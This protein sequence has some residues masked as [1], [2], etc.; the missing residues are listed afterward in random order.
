MEGF[1]VGSHILETQVEGFNSTNLN[2]I[3]EQISEEF[4][5]NS[6]QIKSL[7]EEVARR[8]CTGQVV[9]SLAGLFI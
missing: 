5:P 7:N 9:I 8:I 1:S 6:K 4:Q 3:G 2:Q